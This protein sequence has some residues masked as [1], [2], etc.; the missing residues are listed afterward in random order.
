MPSTLPL[1]YELTIYSGASFRQEFR[2]KPDGEDPQDFTG[3]NGWLRIGNTSRAI[4]EKTLTLTSHG[5]IIV[6]LDTVATR[7]LKSGAYSYN[8]DLHTP[9][10]E[11]IRFLRGRAEVIRDVGDPP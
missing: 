10:D 4:V 11:I 5:R 3:W 6:T 7:T 8:I 1:E 2:W 9:D